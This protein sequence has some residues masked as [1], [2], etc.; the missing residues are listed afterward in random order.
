MIDGDTA[1]LLA[2]LEAAFAAARA[3]PARVTE[4]SSGAAFAR[5]FDEA[6]AARLARHELA[7]LFDYAERREAGLAA[8]RRD[9][10]AEARDELDVAR[11]LLESPQLSAEA[12]TIGLALL[13][14]AEAYLAYRLGRFADARVLLVH[15]SA[16]DHVLVR[17]LGY[18]F[19]S[20]HRLQIAHNLLRIHTRL[21]E[22]EEAVRLAASF[23]DYLEAGLDCVPQSLASPRA[24]LRSVPRKILAFY[25][26]AFAAEVAAVIAGDLDSE[27][28]ALFQPLAHHGR[29]TACASRPIGSQG[30]RWCRVKMPALEGDPEA[31][32]RAATDAIRR[33]R[34]VH[35]A[36]WFATLLD[37]AAICPMLGP[38]GVSA[39]ERVSR[40]ATALA[41]APHAGS[42]QRSSLALEP[43]GR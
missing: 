22:V 39:G 38:D 34:G 30:H 32:I 41:D 5:L 7:L 9:R 4:A 17:D 1:R 43:S 24:T 29:P 27:T 23:L 10:L 11:T 2:A 20:A 25:F 26:D 36:L 3:R 33:G 14:P 16:L 12:A 15:A 21:G 13:E 42:R 8:A 19:M 35:R 28:A 40:A 31:A 37:A 6:I 18:T